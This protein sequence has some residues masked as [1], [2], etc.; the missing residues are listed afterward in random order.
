MKRKVLALVLAAALCLALAA[1]AL[2]ADPAAL[3]GVAYVGDVAAC[4]MSPEMARAYAE[5]LAQLEQSAKSADPAA[6]VDSILLDAGNDGHPLLLTFVFI[7]GNVCQSLDLWEYRD[8]KTSEVDIWGGAKGAI[9]HY[10]PDALRLFTITSGTL[11]GDS[12][13]KIVFDDGLGHEKIFLYYT[14]SHGQC[15]LA[16]CVECY[17]YYEQEP[18]G[19]SHVNCLIYR[20][21]EYK[22]MG[23]D[24]LVSFRSGE[25]LCLE[26]DQTV[27]L[28]MAPTGIAAMTAALN[29]YAAEAPAA[30]PL[31]GFAYVG[32]VSACKMSPEMARAYADAIRRTNKPVVK[33]ALFDAGG[34]L[35]LLWLAFGDSGTNSLIGVYGTQ[36]YGF[37]GS[38]RPFDNQ[39]EG[40]ALL[41]AGENGVLAQL[42]HLDTTDS[43]A[44]RRLSG[45]RIA[46]TPFATGSYSAAF[47]AEL[48]GESLGVLSGGLPAF[49]QRL[50]PDLRVLLG[51]DFGGDFSGATGLKLIGSWSDGPA[52]AAALEAY[53]AY[54]ASAAPAAAVGVTVGG[55][56]VPWTDAAP[57]I[58]ENNRTMV[59]LR[60]VGDALGLTVGWDGAKREA[61]FTDGAK[62]LYF[63]IDSSVAR[64][65]DGGT[66]RMDT[67]A[68]IVNDRTY[69][70]VRYLAEFFGHTVDWDGATK[71][72]IIK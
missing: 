61:S 70:P 17:D 54:A 59:P 20:D 33:A 24:A 5:R 52:M 23:A 11:D 67:A 22:D 48:N 2:A 55:K 12:A 13:L 45:G 40:M 53:A 34:G 57:F 3:S 15:A 16:G 31:S 8:G 29:A 27:Q 14:V 46:E 47:G 71:T 58:D 4:N 35:P 1:P 72:V 38:L 25:Q 37:D 21:R 68:V 30:S 39:M 51:A 49:Y 10:A 44:F 9:R 69:A 62:T 32:D 42:Y 18:N 65:G 66:V 60:A 6:A 43:F 56:P 26:H 7:E 36:I 28:S 50:E 41:R 19:A 64:T 63:P